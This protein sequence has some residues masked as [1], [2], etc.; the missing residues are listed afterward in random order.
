MIEPKNSSGRARKG[1]FGRYAEQIWACQIIGTL[2]FHIS[3]TCEIPKKRCIMP[4][5][6]GWLC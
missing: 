1:K 3:D 4:K 5:L 2:T 6:R